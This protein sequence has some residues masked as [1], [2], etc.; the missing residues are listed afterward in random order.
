MSSAENVA[1]RLASI[2]VNLDR[3][4]HGRH[5]GDDCWDCGG[6]SKGNPHLP[7]PGHVVGYDLMGNPYIM[8]HPKGTGDPA[9]WRPAS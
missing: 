5:A 6:P 1:G 8:P 9:S 3:C 2:L 4:P 7:P